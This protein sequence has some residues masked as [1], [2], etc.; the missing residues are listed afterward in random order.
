MKNQETLNSGKLRIIIILSVIA[1]ILA[2]PLIAMQFTNEVQWD[3][4]DFVAAGI[5]LLST[6]LAIELVIRNM[7]TGT[8]RTIVLIAILI[9]LFLIWA[10]MAVGIFGSPIAGS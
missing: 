6:G 1:S 2:I 10:E 3:L 5:L 9:A 4:R 8:S 7:K